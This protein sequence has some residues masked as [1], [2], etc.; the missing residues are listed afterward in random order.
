M[1]PRNSDSDGDKSYVEDS[2]VLG[3]APVTSVSLR[4]GWSRRPRP[5]GGREESAKM[6][7]G[8][9]SCERGKR[10]LKRDPWVLERGFRVPRDLGP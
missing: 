9:R 10:A 3:R 5:W 4:R 1:G 2:W 8:F 7:G 6:E